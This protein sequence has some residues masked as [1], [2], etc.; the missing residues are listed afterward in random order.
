MRHPNFE[1]TLEFAREMDEKDPLKGFR[2]QFFLPKKKGKEALYFCGNSLGLQPR[3]VTTYINKDLKKWANQGVEG[4]FE[5]EVPWVDARKPSK[6]HL[7]ALLGAKTE[8]VVAMNSLTVNLHLL[9]VSFYRPNGK[10]YKIL[11]ESG[12]FPSDQ[13]VLESQLKYHGYDPEEA[14]LEVSPRPG[15]HILRTEDI[16]QKICHYKDDLALVMMSGVQYYTGQCFDMKAISREAGLHGIKV[17]LDLAHAIGNVP[18]SLHD[19]GV[20]FA[21]WCSYKYLNAGPGN[22]SGVFVHQKHGNDPEIP[23]FAGWWGYLEES[24]F[25][26]KKGF[27]PM[28]GADGWLLSNDPVLGLGALQA[29]LDIFSAAGLENIWTKSELLTGYLEFVIRETIGSRDVLQIITPSKPKDRGCQL[30]VL[31]PEGGK[32]IVEKW[33]E[34]GVVVD[35]RKPNVV[36]LAPVPLYNTFQEVFAFSKILQASLT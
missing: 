35:W 3:T 28:Q 13:Y 18:L 30:S 36:R 11:T 19:W 23:R 24:R 22:V 6:S 27:L 10:K 4:H 14:L 34:N 2:N 5:G 8:E 12:A 21:T 7:A 1:L 9:L 17:G 29:S 33:T 15:E 26:M 25:E 32:E 31:I 20:D 16:L